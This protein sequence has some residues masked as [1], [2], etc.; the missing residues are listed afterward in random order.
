MKKISLIIG[1]TN[2]IWWKIECHFSTIFL[3]LIL[4]CLADFSFVDNFTFKVESFYFKIILKKNKFTILS[5]FLVKNLKWFFSFYTEKILLCFLIYLDFLWNQFVV[6][7]LGQLLVL[8]VC[9]NLLQLTYNVFWNKD[10]LI[11]TQLYNHHLNQL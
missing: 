4:L 5:Q 3:F 11:N 6:L 9:L 2:Y 7:L 10:N 1:I 8:L